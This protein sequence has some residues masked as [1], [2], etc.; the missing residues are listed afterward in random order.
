MFY[1]GNRQGDGMSEPSI[2]EHAARLNQIED[3]MRRLRVGR[4]TVF[5][6]LAS[7]EL[8]SVK[9]GRRRLVPE[10]ALVDYIAGLDEQ[11]NGV[12]HAP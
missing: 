5:G 8:R 12:G 2:A 4:S 11:G 9:I 7:G 6:L 3:I 10:S 1:S